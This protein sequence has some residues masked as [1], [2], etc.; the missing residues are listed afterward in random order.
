ME[1]GVRSLEAPRNANNRKVF[2]RVAFVFDPDD[3]VVQ[4]CLCAG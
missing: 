4:L 3:I 2:A 1:A